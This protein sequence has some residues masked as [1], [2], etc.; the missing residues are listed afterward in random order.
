M[1]DLLIFN[2][3]IITPQKVLER[4]WIICRDGRIVAIGNDEPT[5]KP[6]SMAIDGQGLTLLPGFVD[7]HAHGAMGHAVMHAT[8]EAL[9]GMSKFFARHGVTSFLATTQ[10]DTHNCITEALK[11]IVATIKHPNLHAHLLGAHIESPYVNWQYGNQ[12]TRPALSQEARDWLSLGVIKLLTLA[13]EIPENEWLIREAVAQGITVSVGHSDATY[14]QMEQ[15][16]TI[17]ITHSTHTFHDMR[18]FQ[19]H[20]AGVVGAV[21]ESCLVGCD[22]IADGVHVSDGAIRLLWLLKRPD[23]LMLITDS[24]YPA[25][26][27]DGVFGTA[28]DD[29]QVIVTDGVARNSKGEL[30]GGIMPMDAGLRYLMVAL[31]EPIERVWQTASLNPAHAIH[32]AHRKGSIEIGKDAD[33]VLMD[34]DMRVQKTIVMGRVV[35]EG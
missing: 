29:A 2:T 5:R 30:A 28:I 4:G 22:I 31:R 13:P 27:G 1:T 26:L 11:A 15:A 19:H 33:L 32:V 34:S 35:Y 20:E 21:M 7:I 10:S 17:G 18:P 14:D 9:I 12:H 8:P 16:I 6:D 3:H 23:K 24:I 25:G